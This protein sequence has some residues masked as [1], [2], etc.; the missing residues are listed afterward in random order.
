MKRVCI[1]LLAA[2]TSPPQLYPTIYRGVSVIPET[3]FVRLPFWQASSP[4]PLLTRSHAHLNIQI[5]LDDPQ[6]NYLNLKEMQLWKHKAQLQLPSLSR[7]YS[8]NIKLRVHRFQDAASRRQE[9]CC[10]KH[11]Y[12]LR[13]MQSPILEDG[14]LRSTDAA[15]SKRPN[16]TASELQDLS[17]HQPVW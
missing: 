2:F 3:E 17:V 4:A 1:K 15:D 7:T 9:F 5:R 13:I 6:E 16:V 11:T 14:T 12:Y 10:T 8:L